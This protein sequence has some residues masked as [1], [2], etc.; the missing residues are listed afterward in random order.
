MVLP[1]RNVTVEGPV[2][3]VGKGALLLFSVDVSPC[4]GRQSTSP[5][6]TETV[7][8][9]A[10]LSSFADISFCERSDD[11]SSGWCRTSVEQAA[12]AGHV[13]HDI[14]ESEMSG[15][16]DSRRSSQIASYGSSAAEL[17]TAAVST[18]EDGDLAESL[19]SPDEFSCR[20][21]SI[22]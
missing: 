9:S 22:Y 16:T 20:H 7:L 11:S 21:Q 5:L 1:R 15:S 14:S 12:A 19:G 2:S 18:V 4:M 10:A 13:E 8:V 6:V 3:A 17:E